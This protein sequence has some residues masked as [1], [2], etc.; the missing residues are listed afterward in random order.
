MIL[1][2]ITRLVLV[3]ML[4]CTATY[5]FVYLY[6]WEW[7]RAIVVGLFFV[8]AEVGLLGVLLLDRLRSLT[9]EVDELRRHRPD[10]RVLAR[11]QESGPHRR[12]PFAWLRDPSP[13]GVF[14][15]V[16]L[17]AGVA[18]SAVAWLVER[19][20]RSTTGPVMERHLARRLGALS[21]PDSLVVAVDDP[22]RLLSEPSAG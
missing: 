12:E 15:P 5:V 11:L 1:R 18:L 3:A 16:L 19:L 2:H 22:L 20:A 13:F 4:L 21:L 6:R 17:G 8:I 9:R 7:N 10:P 14:V